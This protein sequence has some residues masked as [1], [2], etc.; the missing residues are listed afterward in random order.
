MPPGINLPYQPSKPPWTQPP[1]LSHHAQTNPKLYINSS[2]ARAR[3]FR[4]TRYIHTPAA[5]P[6]AAKQE[7]AGE[8]LRQAHDST[9]D[10]EKTLM[11]AE[12]ANRWIERIN[13]GRS[14]IKKVNERGQ[15]ERDRKAGRVGKMGEKRK[16]GSDPFCML[17]RAA[18][19]GACRKGFFRAIFISQKIP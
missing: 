18:G 12:R 17:P 6:L 10:F 11:G 2:S 7:I 15:R 4:R 5:N 9:F 14:R 3:N 8:R 16:S 1:L 13:P 19:H